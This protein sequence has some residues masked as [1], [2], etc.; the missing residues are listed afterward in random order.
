MPTTRA[1][2]PS[3]KKTRFELF[4]AFVWAWLAGIACLFIALQ[5]SPPRWSLSTMSG[6]LLASVKSSLLY[7]LPVITAIAALRWRGMA[8]MWA[9]AGISLL[10]TLLTVAWWAI[11]FHPA[12]WMAALRNILLLFPEIIVPA[13]LFW[14]LADRRRD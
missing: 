5:F 14:W 3:M 13:L 2:I 8:P 9:A 1:A 7:V 10:W 4:V 12:P 11:H 6:A